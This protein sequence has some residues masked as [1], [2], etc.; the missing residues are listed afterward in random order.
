MDIAVLGAGTMGR[1]MSA[2]LTR[3]GHRVVL[4]TRAATS[5]PIIETPAGPLVARSYHDAVRTSELVVLTTL[6][7]LTESAVTAARPFCSRVLIDCTNPEGTDGRSLAV[8]LTTSGAE[9]VATWASDARVVK[10]F[11]HVYAEV[12]SSAEAMRGTPT[13]FLAGDDA[14]AKRLVSELVRPLGV[15]PIDAGSLA[16]ARYLE[17]LAML[18]VELVRGQ[19]FGPADITLQMRRSAA[20]GD[21]VEESRDIGLVAGEA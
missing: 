21:H 12:L 6:W 8:G 20:L 15:D 14:P 17:P 7:E 3:H 4:G 2:L 13:L 18:M 10:A 9:H 16:S 5:S 19:G 11:N 1:A